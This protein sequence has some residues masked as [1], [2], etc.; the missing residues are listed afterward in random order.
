ME[1]GEGAIGVEFAGTAV[2]S[3]GQKGP[4]EPVAGDKARGMVGRNDEMQ[5]QEGYYRGYYSLAVTPK[6]VSAQ[7]YGIYAHPAPRY[8][9]S[10]HPLTLFIGSPTVTTRNSWELPLANFTVAHGANHLDRPIAGGRVESGALKF[11]GEILHSNMSMNTDT[12]EWK[13]N[14]FDKMNL[15]Y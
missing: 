15:D 6:E 14:S 5:W 3:T 7:F 12:G 10:F 13:I 1:T 2:S 9:R 11:E 4:I 8:R